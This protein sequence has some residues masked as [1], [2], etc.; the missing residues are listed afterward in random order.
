MLSFEL[1]ERLP[2]HSGAN[3]L[4][5]VDFEV[6][7]QCNTS[8]T[9]NPNLKKT[10]SKINNQWYTLNDHVVTPIDDNEVVN[11]DAYLLFFA[12]TSETPV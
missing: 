6:Q 1:F 9:W 8:P 2:A 4:S 3:F 12:K 7:N 5:G 11:K 10:N